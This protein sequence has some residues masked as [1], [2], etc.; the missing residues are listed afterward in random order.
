MMTP[1][2][3]DPCH[4]GSGKKYKHCCLALDARAPE[5]P[6]DRTWRRVRRAVDGFPR[7]LTRFID[8]VYGPEVLD[9]AWAEFTLWSEDELDADSA[10]AGVF[11]RW[12]Y[13]CWRPDPLEDTIVE[14]AALHGRSPTTEFLARRGARLDPLLRRYLEA[15]TAA[16]FSFHEILASDPG[17]GFASRCVITGEENAVFDRAASTTLTSGDLLFAQLVPIDGIVV[18][19]ACAPFVLGPAHKLQVLELRSRMRQGMG[20]DALGVQALHDYDME[21]RELCLAMVAELADPTPPVLH[22]TDGELVVPQRVTF[23]V[24]SAEQAFAAL[25]HLAADADAALAA[26]ERDAAGAIERVRFTW[27]R[28]ADPERAGAMPAAAGGT[29]LAHLTLT[30]DRLVADLNSVERA[31]AFRR[32]AEEALGAGARYLGTELPPIDDDDDLDAAAE[33]ERARLAELPEVR[34]QLDRMLAAH[35]E[36]WVTESL[37]A[38]GG[39]RPIDAVRD[40]D[41]R[42]AVEALV[43][44]IERD[45]RRMSPPPAE[46]IFERLRERLGL[47]LPK[48]NPTLE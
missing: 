33:D 32:L 35:Y 48:G 20:G 42:E 2:R 34:E 4:C 22:N 28:P 1:G 13:H 26:A 31:Q 25:R 10:L 44:Q 6:G 47:A 38:L 3:N 9:E 39:R 8:D 46:R 23:A 11:A 15:C 14:D 27:H 37:P 21:I 24:D 41:G 30:Q 18:L 17:R 5:P 29:V 43:R 45:A 12:L 36:S 40:P 19:E 7:L 16:P